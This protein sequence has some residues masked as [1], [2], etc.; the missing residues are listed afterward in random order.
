MKKTMLIVNDFLY[1][2]GVEKLMLEFIGFWHQKYNITVMTNRRCRGIEDCFPAKVKWIQFYPQYDFTQIK[3]MRRIG[4]LIVKV[5]QFFLFQHLAYHKYDVLL[6]MKEGRIMRNAASIKA[7]KKLA[8]VHLDYADAYWTDSVFSSTE[9]ELHCMKSYDHVVCVSQYVKASILQKIG[10]PGNLTVR[11][12]PI[13]AKK[14]IEK[15]GRSRAFPRRKRDE[16]IFVS[17]GRLHYQKGFDMLL[18]ACR[19]LN[20]CRRDYQIYI[21]GDGPEREKLVEKGHMLRLENVHF[22][23]QMDN[24]YPYIAEADWL[25]SCARQE[26]YFLVEQEAAVLGIPILATDCFGARELLG[27]AEY[28]I[29][30]ECSPGSICKSIEQVL[31]HR[32]WREVYHKK[33]EERNRQ[34]GLENRIA[35]IEALFE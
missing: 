15:S 31:N 34:L 1:A 17:V 27:N 16:V 32:E 11:Y 24:P 30:M 7:Q 8:W 28:G 9:E 12:N 10:D 20:V 33:I 21:L 25:L 18:E 13:D 14:I 19:Q 6:A 22:L 35:S 26:G 2:G 29:L 3:G 5:Y 23:G 4:E